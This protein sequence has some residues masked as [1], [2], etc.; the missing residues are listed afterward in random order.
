MVRNSHIQNAIRL[1]FPEI[2]H[3]KVTPRSCLCCCR[4]SFSRVKICAST[5]WVDMC[6]VA[7]GLQEGRELWRQGIE[8]QT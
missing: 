5:T 4:H 1:V 3:E 2:P 7:N 6:F 8:A